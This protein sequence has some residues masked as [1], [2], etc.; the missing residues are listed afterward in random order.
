MTGYRESRFKVSIDMVERSEG[1]DGKK[2][3]GEY[4]STTRVSR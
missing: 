1:V 3:L 2:E 4:S